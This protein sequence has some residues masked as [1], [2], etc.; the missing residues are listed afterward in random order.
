MDSDG[1]TRLEKSYTLLQDRFFEF[2]RDSGY[3]DLQRG[4]RG[5]SEKN[6]P[7]A[8]FKVAKEQ[9]RGEKLSKEN[10]KLEENLTVLEDFLAEA[11]DKSVKIKSI[12]E[13]Q[14]KTALIGNKVTVDKDEFE[15]VK[16]LAKQQISGKNKE[17]KL[18]KDLNVAKKEISEKDKVIVEQKKEISGLKST[19]TVLKFSKENTKLK[20]ELEETKEELTYLRRFK[21]E[22]VSIFK[23]D[24]V[25][26]FFEDIGLLARIQELIQEK[27]PEKRKEEKKELR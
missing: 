12:D 27:L 3:L 15:E 16:T 1:N 21:A 17:K 18:K 6:M 9:E 14:E 19:S 22:I 5:S 2:M 25:K 24:K 23:L 4:E 8:Q 26:A 10:D 20:Q 13:I 11:T 7:V